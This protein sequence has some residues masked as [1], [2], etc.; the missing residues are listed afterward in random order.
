MLEIHLFC[1]SQVN[2]F[3]DQHKTCIALGNRPRVTEL[4]P[5]SSID[6]PH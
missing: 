5:D 2:L 4:D 1:H 6:I 3:L